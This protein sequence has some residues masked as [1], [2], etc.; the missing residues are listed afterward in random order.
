MRKFDKKAEELIKQIIAH[1][2][3]FEEEG[4]KTRY[5]VYK[6]DEFLIAEDIYN[7]IDKVKQFIINLKKVISV[8]IKIIEEIFQVPE[9]ELKDM[10]TLKEMKGEINKWI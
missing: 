2:L 8:Y 3:I 9:N 4:T 5:G 7:T 10:E 6:E 1:S